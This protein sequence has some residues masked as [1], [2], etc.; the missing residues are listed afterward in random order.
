M[1]CAENARAHRMR[2]KRKGACNAPKTQG[3]MQ[4]AENAR[5]HAMRQ[6]QQYES[7]AALQANEMN[8]KQKV[9]HA[10]RR[11]QKKNESRNATLGSIYKI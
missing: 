6:K 9:V 11:K 8:R 3:R 10:M 4:C 5:A 1:Q 7:Q 2:R